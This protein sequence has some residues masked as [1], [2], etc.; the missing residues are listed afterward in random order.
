MN[1]IASSLELVGPDH[2]YYAEACRL[3]NGMHQPRPAV[4]ARCSG[5]GDVAAALDHARTAG[6]RVSVRGG[7]HHVAGHAV[8]DGGLVIDTSPMKDVAVDPAAR[9][10]RVGA[11]VLWG[12]LDAATQAYGLAVT[13]GR[14]STTGVVGQALGSGSGW[15]ERRFGLTGDHLLAAELVTA[16]GRFVRATTETEPELF[17]AIR[18]AGANFGAITAL[19][20]RLHPVG[21]VVYGGMLVW[22]GSD[23]AAILRGW[24][25]VNAAADWALGTA[26]ALIT[27]P[28][29]PFVPEELRGRPAVGMFVCWSGDPAAGEEAC[30]PLRAIAPP[31]VDLLGPMPYTEVQKIIEPTAPWGL[32]A[33]WKAE[34]VRVLTDA[35]IDTLV[36]AHAS[37]PSPLT[38]VVIEPKAG[39][40]AQLPEDATAIGGR[41]AS[42]T[43]YA[44]SAWD[45]PADDEVNI[46]W[47]R[48]LA[49][50]MNRF[51]MP[52][53]AL[54]FLDTDEGSRARTAFGAE[55]YERLR[56]IKRAWD[57]ENV[58]SSCANI[59]P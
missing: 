38:A 54:N 2:P 37:C 21:P 58:F 26:P 53:I 17:W 7:R 42:D 13:G 1:T 18:G 41:D 59:A 52:A 34:S 10:V 30:A 56:R 14:D 39:A 47:T 49:A 35:A 45:D 27:A 3:H 29:A 44:F 43:W 57:P 5:P 48:E 23:P 11:G 32:R 31:A 12:E 8:V 25:D 24:R 28:P 40:I 22:D 33:Y 50:A 51:G 20:L 16:D 46:A 36:A 9:T 15:L 6:L 4:V 19:E 55:K